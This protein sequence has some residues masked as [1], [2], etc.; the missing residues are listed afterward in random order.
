MKIIKILFIALLFG[1]ANFSYA[2]NQINGTVLDEQKNVL[3][4][5]NILVKCSNNGVSTDFDGN[6]K[7]SVKI[8]DILVVSYLG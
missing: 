5:A 4:S 2:Q 3:P 6:F 7:I 1:S 8:G